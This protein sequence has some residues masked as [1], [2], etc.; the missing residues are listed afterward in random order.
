MQ[1]WGGASQAL[2]ALIDGLDRYDVTSYVILPEKGGPLQE[3]LEKRHVEYVRLPFESGIIETQIA[4]RPLMDLKRVLG[5]V[6][7]IRMALRAVPYVKKW[8]IDM[9]H[10]N[11]TY[12][13]YGMLLGMI[14]GKPNIWHLR[15][16]LEG[17]FNVTFFQKPF[18]MRFL[19]DQA[20]CIIA[21][22]GYIKSIY[23]ESLNGKHTV[24]SVV[25]D[26]AR[27]YAQKE[28]RVIHH[29]LRLLYGG[30][31]NE[32]KGWPEL[33]LLY[34]G[35]K[36]KGFTDYEIYMPNFKEK[37]LVEHVE[38]MNWDHEFLDHLVFEKNMSREE[39]DRF[40]AGLDIH[41]QPSACEAFGLVTVESMLIG[42][43]VVAVASGANP[44]LMD[45]GISGLL[46]EKGNAL[47]MAEKVIAL[48]ENDELREKIVVNA[49]ERAGKQFI[50]EENAKRIYEIYER[51]LN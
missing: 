11:S 18:V 20:S 19:A 33:Y 42:L 16:D 17:Q 8:K 13:T 10:G 40:R 32:N 34:K 28:D 4:N 31:E 39:I 51:L 48:A 45:Q 1:A 49:M 14:T 23:E 5:L 47:D 30:G 25:Y 22:S 15:E 7:Q 29:P 46:Y 41:V 2:L 38:K 44:E 37:K 50:P 24:F 36:L 3:E 12:V 27:N 43:P 35:M 9:I 21:V 6:R 26:G